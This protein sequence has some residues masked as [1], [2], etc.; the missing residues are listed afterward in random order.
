MSNMRNTYKVTGYVFYDAANNPT[1][2]II[3]ND[4]KE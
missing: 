2:T 1:Y 4:N 3:N